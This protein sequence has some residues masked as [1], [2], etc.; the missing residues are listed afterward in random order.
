ME[1]SLVTDLYRRTCLFEAAVVTCSEALDMEDL[2]PMLDQLL[3]RE[4][5]LIDRKDHGRHSVREL[6]Q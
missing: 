5:A 6:L 1:Y 3:R 4:K 2:P